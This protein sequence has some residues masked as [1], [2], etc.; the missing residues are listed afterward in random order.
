M[1]NNDSKTNFL[2]SKYEQ[3]QR[4]FFNSG[5]KCYLTLI[6]KTINNPN[7]LGMDDET[8][9]ELDHFSDL[10]KLQIN[11]LIAEEYLNLLEL[12]VKGEL[13]IYDF[14]TQVE[15]KDSKSVE[16]VNFLES[17]LIIV[18]MDKQAL[19]FAEFLI[20]IE[21]NLEEYADGEENAEA[22]LT[23]ALKNIYLQMKYFLEK[24]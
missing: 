12:F 18:P 3:E 20:D 22:V 5:K 24:I 8:S 2:F 4:E 17:K 13:S 10:A 23:N 9:G 1:D 11:L 14:F 19:Y 15:E 21:A 16:V 6:K 7:R